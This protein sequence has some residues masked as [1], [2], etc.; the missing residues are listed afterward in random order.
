MATPGHLMCTFDA[1]V[2][3]LKTVAIASR[4][5]WGWVIA[6]SVVEP[7]RELL[8]L[9][10]PMTRPRLLI[11]FLIA[12]FAALLTVLILVTTRGSFLIA[13]LAFLTGLASGLFLKRAR[14]SFGTNNSQPENNQAA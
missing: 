7:N 5:S 4:P 14:S 11:F 1:C 6:L 3:S 9:W 13:A 10:L 12:A 2:K 8:L